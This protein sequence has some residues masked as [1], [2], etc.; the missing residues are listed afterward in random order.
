M[1]WS[2]YIKFLL[3][4]YAP[5]LLS[6]RFVIIGGMLF[7]S[8]A[9][10]GEQPLRKISSAGEE[11]VKCS[12]YNQDIHKPGYIVLE[13]ACDEGSS[14]CGGFI[15]FIRDKCQGKTLLQH[16]CDSDSKEF[17]STR[18]VECKKECKYRRGY[19]YCVS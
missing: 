13:V 5:V 3:R 1:E 19:G 18:S 6:D 10:A 11:P 12:E 4:G 9:L 2:E 15:D 8:L 14:F 17:H 16:Y 7:V